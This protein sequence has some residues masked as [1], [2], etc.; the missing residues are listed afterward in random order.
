MATESIL[1]TCTESLTRVQK[2]KAST[3]SREDDL[4]KQMSFVG[5][6]KPAETIIAVYK[7]IPLS[8]LSDFTDTQLNVIQS[9]ANADFS[10]FKQI[11]DF[12]ATAADAA[13]TRT[14]LLAN[15]G[16]RRDQLF[17]QVWQY[18]AYG[19]ARVTDTSLLETQAR[20]TIQSIQDESSKLTE[21][22]KKAKDDADSALLAIRAVASE[23]G[24]SQQAVHFKQEAE[25]QDKL[26]ATWLNYT[27]KFASAVG[28]FAILSLLLHKLPWI[29]PENNA[30]ALQL[31]TSKIL[32]FAVL[33][34]LLVMAARNYSTHKHNS[35][36][37]R[38]RQNA[39]LTYRS[40]VEATA[41]QG[42]EDI[43]LA[44]AASC[45]FSP[46]ETG[47]AQGRG[48]GSS[49]SKSVLELL[50]KG[51]AKSSE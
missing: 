34:F 21:E 10:V 23:Q 42:T 31:I 2:F 13:G 4:G 38:H 43:V 25:N 9:Q 46:Q 17:D 37:N 7:R 32:I 26:A 24:V 36:V 11:L 49:G 30:E 18:V 27:Y 45:I 22:L 50:T 28:G 8:A 12:D 35:I 1:K 5:A 44:H 40:L 20:S 48:E 3:L 6:I 19:V 51:A 16:V 14:S 33:G 39:L 41:G 15:L 29:K 47:F